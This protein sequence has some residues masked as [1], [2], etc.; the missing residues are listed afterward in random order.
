MKDKRDPCEE[1]RFERSSTDFLP[2]ETDWPKTG[3]LLN[4][5]DE[6]NKVMLRTRTAEKDRNYWNKQHILP[7][8]GLIHCTHAKEAA[9]ILLPGGGALF[10]GQRFSYENY[11]LIPDKRRTAHD[12][13]TTL[14]EVGGY[15]LESLGDL[16]WFGCRMPSNIRP[17]IMANIANHHVQGDVM[18]LRFLDRFATSPLFTG[19]S[20]YGNFAFTAST[21][22]FMGAINRSFA[23]SGS[24]PP[25]SVTD[26][27]DEPETECA[28]L[29]TTACFHAGGTLFY[30]KEVTY[31]VV[32]GSKANC[33]ELEEKGF[34]CLGEH[35]TLSPADK[36]TTDNLADHHVP[37]RKPLCSNVFTKRPSSDSACQLKQQLIPL[38]PHQDHGR[39]KDRSLLGRQKA[40]LPPPTGKRL[41][42][43]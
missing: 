28:R 15:G 27:S 23:N 21:E 11:S 22:S 34:P 19:V 33:K 12:P 4:K 35:A 41:F 42:S 43:L 14:G 9:E 29:D 31:V 17:A 20:M 32:I 7:V 25:P 8:T 10:K 2:I 30:Q 13:C 36:A 5:W 1:A 26:D 39:P 37:C 24:S 18:P 40:F 38:N 6:G 3:W 16:V